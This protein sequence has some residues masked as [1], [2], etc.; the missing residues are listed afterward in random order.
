MGYSRQNQ[1]STLSHQTVT[2]RD[3]DRMMEDGTQ[4]YREHTKEAKINELQVSQL[5]MSSLYEVLS[6]R[7]R[8]S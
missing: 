3:S 7:T 5:V 8:I 6:Y 2:T 1:Y 4:A